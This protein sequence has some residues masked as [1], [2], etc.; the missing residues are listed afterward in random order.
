MNL[1]ELNMPDDVLSPRLLHPVWALSSPWY[2]VA[3]QALLWVLWFSLLAALAKLL[4][5]TGERIYLRLL[6]R[7]TRE[8]SSGE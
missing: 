4:V 2:H 3:R 5:E 7:W 6:E 8:S 1:S